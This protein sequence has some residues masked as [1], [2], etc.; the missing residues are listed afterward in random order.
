[1]T[2]ILVGVL[3]SLLAGISLV[4]RRMDRVRREQ[5]LTE[6]EPE[7]NAPPIVVFTTQALGGFRGLV[8]DWLWLR[9]SRMQDAGNYFEM[10]QLASWIVKL[11]P[12]FTGA[13]AFLAWNMAYNISVTFSSPED[14][15]RWV[16]RGIELIRDEALVLNPGDPELFRELGWIYQHK[17]GQDLDDANRYYKTQFALQMVKVLGGG[18]ADW[19]G[20]AASPG[21][22]EELR[23]ALGNDTRLWD[24][25]ARHGLD[26]TEFEA[27]F[28]QTGTIPSQAEPDLTRAGFS[29]V[30]EL[31]LRRRWLE[32]VYK[33]DPALIRTLNE[34]YGDLDWRLPEAHAIYWASR[35][36]ATYNKEISISCDRMIFQSLSA[37]FKG[38]LLVYVTDPKNLQWLPNIGLVDAVDRSYSE[39]MHRHGEEMVKGAY[40]NF[41]VDA[42]VLLYTFGQRDK[43][44]QYYRRGRELIGRGRFY[45]TLDEFVIEELAED[46]ALASYTQAQGTI[47]GYL[48]QAYHALAAGDPDRAAA[49]E[50][51]A[52]KLWQKYMGY[53]GES[54]YDRR[55][56]P[57]YSDMKREA[58]NFAMEHFPADWAEA[59][60]RALPAAEA[61]PAAGA[62][63]TKEVPK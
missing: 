1:M 38:G 6:T 3:A 36:L 13:H 62:A 15:W 59:L 19:A 39:A 50:A 2:L 4:Q 37:A 28:R 35:G 23:N 56:L 41:L 63:E 5:K 61:K 32:E 17:M 14:R 18:R 21:N 22:Q 33:L 34:R 52:A 55:G 57:P 29:Q 40:G 8:A 46:M 9:S 20:L 49:C 45:K 12:R 43:A 24:I 53:I 47:T 11:Q 25:L 16:Q 44:M 27:A 48:L 54:T 30:V 58:V 31:C 51:I 26:F 7:Y 10:F 42:V 60:R